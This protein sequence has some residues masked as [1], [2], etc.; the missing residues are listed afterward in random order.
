MARPRKY[1]T[2][3][4]AEEANRVKTRERKRVRNRLYREN[5]LTM[6]TIP[7]AGSIK[8][9]DPALSYSEWRQLSVESAITDEAEL[10]DERA[11]AEQLV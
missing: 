11:I 4:E 5:K 10:P 8:H 1:T 9:S 2:K 7:Q 6:R 3:E